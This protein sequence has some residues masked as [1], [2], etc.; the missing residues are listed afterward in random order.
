MEWINRI[1]VSDGLGMQ[2]SHQNLILG[3]WN[4]LIFSAMLQNQVPKG[5][6]L[7]ASTNTFG[8]STGFPPT[9]NGDVY[10]LLLL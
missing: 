8:F 3:I 7:P 1:S 2:M 5:V 4:S 6:E 10:C 9:L